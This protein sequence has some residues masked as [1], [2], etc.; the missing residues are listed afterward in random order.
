MCRRWT[1]AT[2]ADGVGSSTSCG[3][4]QVGARKQTGLRATHPETR[5]TPDDSGLNVNA[6]PPRRLPQAAIAT[7]TPCWF[8]TIATVPAG[9][10]EP[11]LSLPTTSYA[12][13]CEGVM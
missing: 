12:S 3:N 1:P 13:H 2:A 9:S 6:T 7:G 8:S 5:L 11:K 4:A 10:A